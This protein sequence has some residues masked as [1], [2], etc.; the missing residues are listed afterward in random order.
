[1]P[2][3]EDPHFDFPSTL[4][5]VVAPGTTAA[6]MEK[7]VVDPIE[8]EI[9]ELDDLE[10]HSHQHRRRHDQP[11]CGVFFGVDGTKKYDDVVA[12][13]NKVRDQ[14]PGN[15]TAIKTLKLEPSDVSMLQLALVSDQ[16]DYRELK[17]H[18]EAP[19]KQL[20]RVAGV[21]RVDIDALPQLEVQVQVEQTKVNALGISFGGNQQGHSQ[22]QSE[23]PRRLC[24]GGRA[25]LYRAHQWRY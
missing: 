15:V 19:E 24:A 3:S 23:Y 20:E 4:V 16:A 12:A 11:A 2:R 5:L 25:P 9:N 7:L 22:R 18:A 8:S 10:I 6:D 21:K 17:R 14:L 13:L 1:M